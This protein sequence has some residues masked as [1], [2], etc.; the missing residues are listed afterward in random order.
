MTGYL[1]RAVFSAM[2]LAPLA[3]VSAAA[4][5]NPEVSPSG[6]YLAGRSAAKLRD[7]DVASDYLSQVLKSDQGNPQLTEKIFFSIF[8][9]AEC[10]RRSDLPRS[11]E[12]QQPAA[13]GKDRARPQGLPRAPL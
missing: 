7:N 4:Y 12:V 8:R 2:L 6:N 11:G 13:H 1:L 10:P 9:K 5:E 3:A